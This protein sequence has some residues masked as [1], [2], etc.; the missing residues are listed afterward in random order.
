MQNCSQ[1]APEK[2]ASS[3]KFL[4]RGLKLSDQGGGK[5]HLPGTKRQIYL[6]NYAQTFCVENNIT[7]LFPSSCKVF[8]QITFQTLNKDSLADIIC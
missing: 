7:S 2:F 8:D 6:R 3:G 1:A 5:E 4:N